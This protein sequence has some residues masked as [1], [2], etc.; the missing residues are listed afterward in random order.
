MIYTYILMG[1][2]IVDGVKEL[3]R[4]YGETAIERLLEWFRFR[5]ISTKYY[6][7]YGIIF[8]GTPIFPKT[9]ATKWE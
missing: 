3:P 6:P 4:V 9:G 7:E 2:W 1:W 5:V 8:D